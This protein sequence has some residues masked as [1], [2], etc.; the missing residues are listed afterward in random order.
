M[1]RGYDQPNVKSSLEQIMKKTFM[2]TKF[3]RDKKIEV[4]CI[5]DTVGVGYKRQRISKTYLIS[6]SELIPNFL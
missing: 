2:L 6:D 5:K 3:Y 4:F 1:H